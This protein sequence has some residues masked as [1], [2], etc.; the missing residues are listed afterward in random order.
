MKHIYEYMDITKEEFE[1]RPFDESKWDRMIADDDY[2]TVK[3]MYADQAGINLGDADD[4]VYG[5]KYVYTDDDGVERVVFV[6]EVV[7]E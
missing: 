4:S 5:D 7:Q 1:N 6:R 2:Y 3:D